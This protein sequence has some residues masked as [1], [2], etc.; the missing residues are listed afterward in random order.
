MRGPDLVGLS[1]L[2]AALVG[3][4]PRPVLRV[5]QAGREGGRHLRA[6]QG[7]DRAPAGS[8]T[9]SASWR[10]RSPAPGTRRGAACVFADGGDIVVLDTVARTRQQVTRTTTPESSPRWA[11]N[12]TAVTF[13]SQNN[14]FIVP[15]A[16]GA[17]EQLTDVKPRRR[18]TRDTDSQKFV[19]EQEAALL[20]VRPRRRSSSARADEERRKKDALPGVRDHRAPERGPA[21]CSTRPRPWVFLMVVRPG[22]REDHH[23]AQL[24][25]RVG[26]HRGHP[27]AAEGRRRPGPPAPGGPQPRRPARVV[28]ADAVVRRRR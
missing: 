22:G 25:D 24:R 1:A 7:H 3:R 10:R 14:L 19:R 6:L 20:R 13:V 15:L 12:D 4:L 5:A 11:R 9:T 2:G 23:R 18:E 27:V 21:R 28:W 26:L 17:I 8:P 16:T